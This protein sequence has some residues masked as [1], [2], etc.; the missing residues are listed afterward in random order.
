MSAWV[1]GYGIVQ[2]FA[3]NITGKK[4]WACTGRSCGVSVGIGSGG[5]AGGNR[6][7]SEYGAVTA[8]SAARWTD[9]LW[10]A[11]RGEFVAA[12]LSDRVLRQGRRRVAG[13]GV[14]LHVQ[15]H[16]AAHRHGALRLGLSGVW[17]GSMLVDIEC[18][19]ATCSFDFSCIASSC[20]Q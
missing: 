14:L 2:S 3:P 9:G 20:V 17:A 11:V 6:T 19:R 1:I 12:Q 4:T 7:R 16:G 10:S 15:R 18:I 8:G 13:C 5:S